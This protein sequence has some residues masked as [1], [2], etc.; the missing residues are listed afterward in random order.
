MRGP[1][2]VT[3]PSDLVL[4]AQDILVVIGSQEGVLAL[5][6]QGRNTAM[7]ARVTVRS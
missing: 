3:V 7:M 2:F 4:K 5:T 1:S 6:S